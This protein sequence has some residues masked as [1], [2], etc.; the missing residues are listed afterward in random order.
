M[1]ATDLESVAAGVQRL[2]ALTAGGVPLH[3][4]WGYLDGERDET[5]GG[6][7][8][9][10]DA[11]L[12]VAA[13]TGAP[14]ALVL[15]RLAASVRDRA[16]AMR[17]V[18]V[19]LAGPRMTSRLVAALPLVGIGFGML[20]GLDPL[21][22]LLGS[23]IGL[24][25]LVAGLA[26]A[27]VAW[28]WSRRIV[29]AASRGRHAAGLELELVSVALAGGV[30]AEP[31]RRIARGA[32]DAHGIVADDGLALDDTLALA[33]AAG[34]PARSL[35]AAEAASARVRERLA[36]EERAAR[37]AVL[38][39]LPLGVCVLPAFGLLAVV[40][41]SLSMLGATLAPLP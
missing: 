11:A 34:V 23:P 22:A 32:I 25:V 15:E 7:W 13:E 2:A 17:A 12:D 31:A 1:R 19:A 14:V 5:P 35:L 4:A 27:G 10:C 3:A 41:L 8:A 33:T 40:P 18:D 9:M 21:G 38:L 39:V 37:A 6:A 28:L 20:L 30:G 26:L 36:G 24:A 16:A 29:V